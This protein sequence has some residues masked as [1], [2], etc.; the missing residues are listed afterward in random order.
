[1]VLFCGYPHP[2]K[3]CNCYQENKSTYLELLQLRCFC[4][5]SQQ[6]TRFSEFSQKAEVTVQI[7]FLLNLGKCVHKYYLICLDSINKTMQEI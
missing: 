6:Q 7:N 1:M 5:H 4:D 2:P 3:H